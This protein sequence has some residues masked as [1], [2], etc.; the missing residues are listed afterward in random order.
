M[1]KLRKI[2]AKGVELFRNGSVHDFY[3]FK[4]LITFGTSGYFCGRKKKSLYDWVLKTFV[5]CKWV[6]WWACSLC[7]AMSKMMCHIH[8]V[9]DFWQWC[10]FSWIKALDLCVFVLVYSI[11]SETNQ[12]LNSIYNVNILKNTRPSIKGDVKDF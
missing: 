10:N 1:R 12:L 8:Q 11:S 5:V 7:L 3:C 4:A 9:F 2:N 6:L